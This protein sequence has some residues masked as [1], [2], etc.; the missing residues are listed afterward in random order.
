MWFTTDYNARC[1]AVF[2]GKKKENQPMSLQSG[3]WKERKQARPSRTDRWLVSHDGRDFEQL[4]SST[5]RTTLHIVPCTSYRTSLSTNAVGIRHD[6][7]VQSCC[8]FNCQQIHQHA[9]ITGPNSQA[10]SAHELF[11][12][13]NTSFRAI[14]CVSNR[15]SG[16]VLMMHCALHGGHSAALS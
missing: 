2:T 13:C 10:R 8:T 1:F 11:S 4:P 5:N 14:F 12:C 3:H 7:P 6:Q 9:C 16:C 15:Q